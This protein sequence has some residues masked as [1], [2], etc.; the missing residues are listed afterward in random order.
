MRRCSAM[1]VSAAV[2]AA[3]LSLTPGTAS[4][5]EL[6]WLPGVAESADV[7]APTVVA[8]TLQTPTGQ[9]FT[10]GS[11]VVLYVYPS[12]DVV[13]NLTVGE[14][15]TPAPVA[16]GTVDQDGKF[17]LR[18][19]DPA[20]L[21]R[22]ASNDG[23][24]DFEVRSVDEG[25]FAP[26]SLSRELVTVDGAEVLVDPSATD[27]GTDV[28]QEDVAAAADPV[29]L[30]SL[31]ESD[32]VPDLD[33]VGTESF[34]KTDVCGE[35]LVKNLGSKKVVVGSTYAMAGG[36]S[37]TFTY[38]KGASTTIGVGYS[39]SSSAGSFK[40]SGTTSK[41]STSEIGF[42]TRSGGYTYS[43]YFTFGKYSQ[44]CYPVGSGASAKKV[45]AYK[46]HA[47]KFDGGSSVSAAGAPSATKC[48][49]FAG[50][51]S[52]S[53][54]NTAANTWEDG[55]S[56]KGADIGVDLSS[57]TGYTTTATLSYKNSGKASRKICGTND[58]WGGSP[59]RAVTK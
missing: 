49:N 50:N 56:I 34:D 18:V 26:Y 9:S 16:K 42:G 4:A 22:Y 24:I 55:V 12:S 44:W 23:T 43:T 2:I 54:T 45:Y 41:E 30:T 58:T 8:G 36:T 5:D 11:A 47:N 37:G 46:V 19:E 57:K 40:G 32:V 39:A 53:K 17:D 33:P 51:S 31:P 48:T 21:A 59:R 27:S 15:V 52:L 6:E 38:K 7:A 20:S 29:E 14:S 3:G 1:L 25:Y 10:S 28:D 13:D 35:T